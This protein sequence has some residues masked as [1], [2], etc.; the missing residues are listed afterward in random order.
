M[1]RIHTSILIGLINL[2]LYCNSEVRPTGIPANAKHDKKRNVY[3][4]EEAG[5]QK[6]YYEN[7]K[8]YSD[9][10]IDQTK[11]YHGV[12]KT[13]ARTED[14][15]ASEGEYNHG[16]KL[17]KWKWFFPDGKPYILQSY[18]PGP[19]RP[20]S[21]WLG[22]EGN[23]EGTFERYY[24]SGALEL[25]GFYREGRKSDFWQKYFPNGEL[26]FSGT[27]LNGNKVRSWFYYFPNGKTESIEVYTEN[28]KLLSRV[29][30]LPTGAKL[31]ETTE[32]EKCKRL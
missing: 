11:Q 17:G 12:C 26:E 20:E 25:K 22:E 13:F 18:G 24:H 1:F 2:I 6:I 29:L 19:I 15:V 32:L 7:G 21:A 27:Y 28:G 8:L 9:C 31:C 4:L 30:Y 5:R 3:V 14:S 23:E 16:A 10:P